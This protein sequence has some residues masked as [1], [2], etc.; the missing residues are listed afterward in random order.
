L[1]GRYR[2]SHEFSSTCR[3]GAFRRSLTGKRCCVAHYRADVLPDGVPAARPRS[4][5]RDVAAHAGVSLKTV[6]RVVNGER[7]VSARKA[8]VVQDVIRRLDYQPNLAASNLRRRSGKTAAI[9]AVL[10]NI[11]NPYS[12]ALQRALEDAAHERGV[13]VFTGSNDED[14]AREVELVRALLRRRVDALVLAPAGTDHSWLAGDLLAGMPAVFV[15]RAP[16]QLAADA[17]VADNAG[18][19]SV[20]VRHLAAAGH[21]S[22]AFL[23]D[24]GRIST[25]RQRLAGYADTVRELGLDTDPRHVALELHSAEAAAAAVHRM[26]ASDDPPTALFPAQN[27]VTMGAIRALQDLGRQHEV[28]L[29]GFDDFP[30]A[31][32]LQPRVSVVAQD[33]SAIGRQA[34]ALVF[35]RLDGQ[36]WDPVEHVLP[37]RLIPRG[38][39]EIP[40]PGSPPS[41]GRR[42][43]ATPPVPQSVAG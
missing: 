12:A 33:P 1:P 15:D 2:A 3:G 4:T 10:E 17:V 27:L 28:A 5:M 6:S 43:R 18:G 32:L 13:L 30:V 37:V 23:G 21:R 31:D 41:R 42:T 24:L 38:S 35:R 40:V 26:L 39:G 7:G 22:I 36:T 29:V 14:P 20:A 8:G 25:A 11:A 34:A 9:G 16:S 19:A